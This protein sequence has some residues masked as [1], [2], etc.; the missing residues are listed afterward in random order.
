MPSLN[1]VMLIGNVGIE[2]E[3]RYL[4]GNN[5]GGAGQ[6][7]VASFRLATTERFRDRSGETRENTEWHSVSA[8]R[9]L[10]DTVEKYVH[11]GTQLYVEGR[12]RSREYTDQTGNK[13]YRTEIVADNIQLL[14]RRGEGDAP[15]APA[16]GGWAPQSAAPAQNAWAPQSAAPAQGGWAP[17]AP[18][19][20]AYPPQAPAAPAAPAG[21]VVDLG[22]DD[23]SDDLPF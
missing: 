9:G 10:A 23:P 8:W 16:Q 12:I 17:Q 18:A 11:K 13:R 6:A 19:Q 3:V 1:K 15:E 4:D 2:P 14:G 22:I 7:K 20:P 21:P 5:Q